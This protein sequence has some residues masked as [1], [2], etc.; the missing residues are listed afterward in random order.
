MKGGAVEQSGLRSEVLD[1]ARKTPS[2][3]KPLKIK[4]TNTKVRADGRELQVSAPVVIRTSNQVPGPQSGREQ[5]TRPR[6]RGAEM[7]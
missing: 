3:K 7:W 6:G 2:W 1:G 4:E 5:L